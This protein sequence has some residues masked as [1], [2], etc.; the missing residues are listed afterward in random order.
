MRKRLV[1]VLTLPPALAALGLA[2]LRPAPTRCIRPQPLPPAS[3]GYKPP[4]SP[5]APSAERVTS[6]RYEN[7]VRPYW[8]VEIPTGIAARSS[9]R[10]P[11]LLYVSCTT[12]RFMDP[13]WRLPVDVVLQ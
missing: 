6:V 5:S 1:K 9:V 7:D 8:Q 10:D 12:R 4:R 13:A 2:R 11:T 3:P